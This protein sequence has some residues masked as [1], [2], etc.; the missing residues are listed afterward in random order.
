VSL[1]L[2]WRIVAVPGAATVG[3]AAAVVTANSQ[4]GAEQIDALAWTAF[5]AVL[6]TSLLALWTAVSASPRDPDRDS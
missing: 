6:A 5:L 1:A 2:R 4:R 3:V